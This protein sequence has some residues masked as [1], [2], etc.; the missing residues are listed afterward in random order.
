MKTRQ[1]YNLMSIG[2][3]A[4][5]WLIVSPALVLMNH[6]PISSV[7]IGLGRSVDSFGILLSLLQLLVPQQLIRWHASLVASDPDHWTRK[8]VPVTSGLVHVDSD[9]SWSGSLAVR[10]VRIWGVVGVVLFSLVGAV[11]VWIL[12]PLDAFFSFHRLSG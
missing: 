8:L 5:A 4:L 2:W 11:L 9:D 1:A 12:G 6:N 3:M 10:R 7:L